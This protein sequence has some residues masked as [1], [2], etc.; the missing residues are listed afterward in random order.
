MCDV[1]PINLHSENV[2]G[3]DEFQYK[4]LELRIKNNATWKA[5]KT[6][7]LTFRLA[8]SNHYQLKNGR[9]H[10]PKLTMLLQ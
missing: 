5:V 10:R 9:R 7:I 3:E 2:C 1:H 8:F 6:I 4:K